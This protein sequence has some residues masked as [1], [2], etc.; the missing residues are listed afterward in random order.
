MTM[1]NNVARDLTALSSDKTAKSASLPGSIEP[2]I[3][4]VPAKDI[5]TAKALLT[6]VGGKEV[7]RDPAWH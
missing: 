7:Y 2:F 3:L 5:R 1:R 6:H 4:T